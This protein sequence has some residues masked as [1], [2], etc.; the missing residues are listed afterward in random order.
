M[1]KPDAVETSQV[2]NDPCAPINSTM[3]YRK[4]ARIHVPRFHLGYD[5]RF[6][7]RRLLRCWRR[8]GV[9]HRSARGRMSWCNNL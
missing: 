4:I 2:P 5:H 8:T 6:Q 7:C 3:R 1:G 9:N